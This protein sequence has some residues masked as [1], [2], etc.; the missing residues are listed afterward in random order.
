MSET[1]A[2]SLNGTT[3]LPAGKIAAIVTSLEMLSA[4]TLG[5]D[6][7]G[8]EGF[9]LEEIGR[10]DVARYL[11]IYRLL[12][13]LWREGKS[14]VLVTHDI[15][16]LRHLGDAEKVRVAGLADGKLSFEAALTSERLPA[17]LEGLV[18]DDELDLRVLGAQRG[19]PVHVDEQGAVDHG[20]VVGVDARRRGQRLQREVAPV[21]VREVH[22]AVTA[23]AGAQQYRLLGDR[24]D[25]GLRQQGRRDHLDGLSEL[26]GG[27]CI[28]LELRQLPSQHEQVEPLRVLVLVERR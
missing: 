11:A 7:P 19:Q 23:P 5:V 25:R 26:L 4:P 1:F 2:I 22:E 20:Q 16:L 28:A 6:P 27:D 12:G 17:Q 3:D 9:S 21:L 8:V 14:I 18:E 10:E 24:G 15:N 13:E